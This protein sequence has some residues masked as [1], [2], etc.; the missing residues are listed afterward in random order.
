MTKKNTKKFNF[1]AF[2]KLF[3]LYLILKCKFTSIMKCMREEK[4]LQ[5]F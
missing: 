5:N 1:G 3:I 4:K 2:R